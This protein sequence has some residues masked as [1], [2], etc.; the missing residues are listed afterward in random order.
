[1][2]AEEYQQIVP[3]KESYDSDEEIKNALQALQK[4]DSKPAGSN[5]KKYGCWR[6]VFFDKCDQKDCR[7]AHDKASI[8]E[9]RRY[10]SDKL[11]KDLSKDAIPGGVLKIQAVTKKEN[12][13]SGPNDLATEGYSSDDT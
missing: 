9:A 11:R 1:M 10:Y 2:D 4:F 5:L 12:A 8:A 7:H 6:V 3:E 13:G